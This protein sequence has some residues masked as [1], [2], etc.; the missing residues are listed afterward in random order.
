[1]NTLFLHEAQNIGYDKPA[2]LG[3]LPSWCVLMRRR[4]EPVPFIPNLPPE[5]PFV[6]A[7]QVLAR[8]GFRKPPPPKFLKRLVE[9]EWGEQWGEG[10]KSGL[11]LADGAEDDEDA[12]GGVKVYLEDVGLGMPLPLGPEAFSSPVAAESWDLVD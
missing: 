12:D 6:A 2:Q 9:E 3:G 11:M 7:S 1:M 5:E 4:Q 10:P 8:D